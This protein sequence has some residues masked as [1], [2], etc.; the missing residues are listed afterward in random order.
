MAHIHCHASTLE[1]LVGQ[2]GMPTFTA[3]LGWH[4]YSG[5]HTVAHMHIEQGVWWGG[6]FRSLALAKPSMA[7]IHVEQIH[8]EQIHAEQRVG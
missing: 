7:H 6:C 3:N 2:G 4:T 1:R 5:T 8:V